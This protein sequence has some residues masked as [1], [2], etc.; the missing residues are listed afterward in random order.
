MI[1]REFQGHVK[2]V[3]N[4][5]VHAPVKITLSYDTDTD[6]LA[7]QA[8]FEVP[9]EDDRVW[10]FSRELLMGGLNSYTPFGQGDVKF[11]YFGPSQGVLMMC[12]KSPEAHA[13]I[14]MPHGEVAAFLEETV[15]AALHGIEAIDHLI[16]EAIEE[17]LSS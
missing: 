6:P 14:A 16:D 1:T 2:R 7:V 11:R 15:D 3:G 8:I 17:I 12:L 13:D 4:Q 10:H 9:G 5:D